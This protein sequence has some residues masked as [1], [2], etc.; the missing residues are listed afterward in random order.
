VRAATYI[1]ES[2]RAQEE[3]FSPDAQRQALEQYA[4]QQSV[5]IVARY[6]DFESG[7]KETREGFQQMLEAA[8]ASSPTML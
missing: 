4:A 7:T 2:T 5:E 1:R 6:C 8:Q 3:G